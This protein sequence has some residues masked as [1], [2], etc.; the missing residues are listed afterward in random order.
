MRHA[1]LAL[2]LAACF[3]TPALGQG[4]DPDAIAVAVDTT[5]LEPGAAAGDEIGAHRFVL[6]F[7]P[8]PTS[9]LGLVRAKFESEGIFAAVL[10]ELSDQIAL[11]QDVPVTF[12]QCGFSNAFWS[13]D[14]GTITMCW[15]LV[16]DYNASYAGSTDFENG[17]FAWA[18]QGSVLTG[19]TLFVLL[20][21]IGHGMV[22]LF[23]L[24]ITGREEDAMDQFAATV[25]IDSDEADEPIAERASR[26]ALLGALFFRQL[27]QEPAEL[28][29]AILAN[30]HALGQQRY[31][32]V[33]CLVLGS[34]FEAYAP[35]IIPGAAMVF[36]AADQNPDAFDQARLFDWLDKTDG[37]NS[38]PIA[39]ALR[40]MNEY[41]RYGASWDYIAETFMVPQ[42]D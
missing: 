18:D 36:D 42:V 32:D 6:A 39:R 33:M 10:D 5:P 15:E 30:E 37:L 26:F 23:D 1:V 12:T 13:P 41:A 24:P 4:V 11:P 38:L 9:E 25:L 16:A 19:T 20:H 31:Y 2:A 7:E 21:E 3:A 34:D 29:R 35:A 8:A 40:C 22:S 17:L 28:S 27:A 14:E